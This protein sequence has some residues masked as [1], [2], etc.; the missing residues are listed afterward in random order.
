M[1]LATLYVTAK[2]KEEAEKI[3]RAL[4]E[5][6]LVACCNIVEGITSLFPW[7]GEVQKETECL[8]LCKTQMRLIEKCGELVKE[9]HSYEVPC[10]TALPVLKYSREFADWVIGETKARTVDH[11]D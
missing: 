9:L 3:G 10:I 6:K 7:E 11:G 4:I 1:S 8:M 5:K 2:D